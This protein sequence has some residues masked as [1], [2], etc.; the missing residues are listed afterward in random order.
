[1]TVNTL[2][3]ERWN[4][5]AKRQ[6]RWIVL[7]FGGT[8]VSSLE[9]WLQVESVVRR[10][11]A[12]WTRVLVVHSA[13]DGVTEALERLL[14][15][16][17]RGEHGPTLDSIVEQHGR[18]TSELRVAETVDVEHE[19]EELRRLLQ[20]VS[21]LRHYSP[22]ILARVMACGEL[23]AT[24][25][26]AAFLDSKGIPTR[27]ADARTLL[28]TTGQHPSG[29][30]GEYLMATCDSGPDRQL[31]QRLCTDGQ[32][33]LTQGFIASNPAGKTVL[34]G[35]GGSDTSAA[36]LAARLEADRLE[37]WTDVAGMF[38]ADPRLVPS[39]RL[40]QALDYGEAQEIATT[41]GM[42]LHPR[43]IPAVRGQ[44]I[45]VHIGN[46]ADPEGPRTVISHEAIE[47]PPQVKAISKKH[48]VQ[49]IS[50]E[51]LG[52]WQQVGFLADIFA[53]FSECG[54][55]ID[56]VSTSEANVTVS[57]DGDANRLDD[58][59]LDR[60]VG[61]LERH[62]RVRIISPCA[63]VSL[64]GRNIRAMLHR[65][66]PALEAFEEE[67]IHMLSQAASDLNLTVVIDEANADRLVRRLHDLLV[68]GQASGPVFGPTWEQLATSTSDTAGLKSTWWQRSRE[69]LIDLARTRPAAY[70]YDLKTVGDAARRLSSLRSIDR[71]FYAMKANSHPAVLETLAD[72][73]LGIECVS[74][75]EL[76]HVLAHLG[77]IE[78]DRILFTPNFAPRAEYEEAV[79]LGVRLTLDSDYP[80]RQWPEI[81]GDAQIMLRIDPGHGRGHHEKVRTAGGHAKFGVRSDDLD[82]F[83]RLAE[84][85]GVEVIG[86]HAHSGSGIRDERHW[87]DV[88]LT[89]GRIAE[90]IPS[91]RILNL[92]GG[93][94]VPMKSGEAPLD[95]DLLDRELLAAK[96]A[97]P[98]LSF[99]LE[100]GRYLVAEAGVLLAQ[101]TQTRLK[102]SMRYVGV[103]T[104]MNSL[105]RPALY[106]SYHAIVN[107]TRLDS[108]PEEIV[109]V[110][111]PICESGDRLGVG[112]FFPETREGDVLLIADVGAYG[113]AMA[114]SYNLRAP[115]PELLIT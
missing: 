45:P 90:G 7:K 21:L 81:F 2:F 30:P 26:G 4:A 54:L 18:L 65:L 108:L 50:M 16:A 87:R 105:I 96:Q 33:M 106:G 83:L 70:V 82:E 49:V 61:L 42:V 53:C 115:A 46:T 6:D 107:L 15:L 52:M 75:D 5:V 28:T 25:I 23:V 112:R 85:S 76:Q 62:C 36:Y 35:R 48:R 20:G 109:T 93:L 58:V 103:A 88:A 34:L 55:S 72:A 31:R 10:R 24:R 22:E 57:L 43:C 63:A 92:G 1:M 9:R 66:A 111:G 8:S 38:S 17:V 47:A 13:L 84:A 60:L 80:L 79:R 86:L 41:G 32:V 102:G 67:A 91:V 56:L 68:E 110:V 39:A 40:L 12:E 44:G 74:I 14:G 51:T 99:W 3:S 19:F 64:V 29:E 89:L 11:R 59:T 77:T 27:W 37:I 100:P 95:L 113:R 69:Q 104:G 97:Y 94:A 71:V 98:H 114:S 101:V 78:R 73:G